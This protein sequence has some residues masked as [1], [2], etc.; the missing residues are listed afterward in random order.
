[1]AVVAAGLQSKQQDLF[2]SSPGIVG[3]V[4]QLKFSCFRFQFHLPVDVMWA[5]HFD[6]ANTEVCVL[7]QRSCRFRLHA[8]ICQ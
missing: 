1:M 6:A 3:G 5:F 8:C 7:M 4:T 2:P